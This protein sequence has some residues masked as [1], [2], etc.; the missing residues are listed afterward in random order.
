M[1]IQKFA[2]ICLLQ[3]M[4]LKLPVSIS[5]PFFAPYVPLVVPY[6]PFVAQLMAAICYHVCF[7]RLNHDVTFEIKSLLSSCANV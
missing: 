1:K 2:P 5:L 3:L 7:Q 4:K 6:V